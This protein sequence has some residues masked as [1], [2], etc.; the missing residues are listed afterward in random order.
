MW[1]NNSRVVSWPCTESSIFF[2]LFRSLSSMFLSLPLL[3]SPTHPYPGPFLLHNINGGGH[4]QQQPAA[5]SAVFFAQ[6]LSFLL[7][8]LYSLLPNNVP[9]RIVV[10]ATIALL[11]LS[12]RICPVVVFPPFPYSWRSGN[13]RLI[14]CDTQRVARGQ[15]FA[16]AFATTTIILSFSSRTGEGL[17]RQFFRGSEHC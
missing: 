6:S 1:R 14:F 10:Y 2:T 17:L 12:L 16:A 13:L 7:P 3:P 9:R 4:N 11:L 15:S 5:I 8:P